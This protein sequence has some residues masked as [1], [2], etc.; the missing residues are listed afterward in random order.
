MDLAI[1]RI[2]EN[3]ATQDALLEPVFNNGLW[4]QIITEACKIT[5]QYFKVGLEIISPFGFEVLEDKKFLSNK[6]RRFYCYIGAPY[7]SNVDKNEV[8][9]LFKQVLFSHLESIESRMLEDIVIVIQNEH[10]DKLRPD[11]YLCKLTD[12]LIDIQFRPVTKDILSDYANYTITT[13]DGILSNKGESGCYKTNKMRRWRLYQLYIMQ[14]QLF[15]ELISPMSP[16]ECAAYHELFNF[17]S[18][19]IQIFYTPSM[20][21][22]APN[23]TEQHILN[24]LIKPRLNLIKNAVLGDSNELLEVSCRAYHFEDML[25]LHISKQIY[26]H[27]FNKIRRTYLSFV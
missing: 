20:M 11:N 2:N 19:M 25:N 10:L 13:L 1:S 21:D 15:G 8:V 26:W 9:S 5:D 22:I 17:I 12:K 23:A 14:E 24:F 16:D 3:S 18:N 4:R 6:L 7:Q 27:A